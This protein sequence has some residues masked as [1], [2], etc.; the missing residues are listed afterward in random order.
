MGSK[1][2]EWH[3][4][5]NLTNGRDQLGQVGTEEGGSWWYIALPHAKKIPFL[6]HF[7]LGRGI[8]VVNVLGV[9]SKPTQGRK[10]LDLHTASQKPRLSLRKLRQ[11]YSSNSMRGPGSGPSGS[12]IIFEI[13][14]R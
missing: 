5:P 11:E 14:G 8:V 10:T 1:S 7:N 9:K 2:K 13:V 6:F 3:P 12:N 4:G